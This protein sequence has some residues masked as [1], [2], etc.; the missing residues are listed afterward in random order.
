MTEDDP[1]APPIQR[2]HKWPFKSSYRSV[3][4]CPAGEAVNVGDLLFY[5]SDGTIR[6][7]SC[8]GGFAVAQPD[9]IV[10]HA[11]DTHPDHRPGPL[12]DSH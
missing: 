3:C 10:S 7:K 12:A 9:G 1:N 6:R 8:A 11:S 5:M 2:Q 4:G